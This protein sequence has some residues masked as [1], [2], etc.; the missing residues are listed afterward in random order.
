MIE[1]VKTPSTDEATKKILIEWFKAA[2]P[3]WKLPLD[4]ILGLAFSIMS[5]YCFMQPELPF[6][7]WL[8]L[9]GAII[10]FL[11]AF[12]FVPFLASVALG[13]QKKLP[14]YNQK[15]IY[16]FHNDHMEYI[17]EGQQPVKIP[18]NRFTEVRLVAQYILMLK[19]QQLVLWFAKEDIPPNQ[20]G[21]LFSIFK[22]NNLP[23]RGQ[24]K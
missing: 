3:K 19:D 2:R 24:F 23:V 9:A 12:F 14:S 11:T 15:K 5:I 17:C 4:I 22:E 1:I 10:S 8:A 16:R 13:A 21:S 18:L 7:T 20:E 6:Y